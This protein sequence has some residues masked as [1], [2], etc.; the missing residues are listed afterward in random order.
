MSCTPHS[1]SQETTLSDYTGSNPAGDKMDSAT[2]FLP[3]RNRATIR[4]MML[5]P[6]GTSAGDYTESYTCRFQEEVQEF[7]KWIDPE[8]L[9]FYYWT[10]SERYRGDELYPSFNEPG[11]SSSST[12][13]RSSLPHLRTQ[14]P[15][16]TNL[17]STLKHT[18][19]DGAASQKRFNEL[20]TTRET[21]Y[22]K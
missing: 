2:G 14:K 9:P 7:S 16:T 19:G 22:Q 3:V 13:W 21:F 4:Q 18:M 5:R 15:N 17:V 6:G 11:N 1:M 12:R 8:L 10:S 20:K